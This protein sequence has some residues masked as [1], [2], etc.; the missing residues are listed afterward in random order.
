MD[1]DTDHIMRR[2][3]KRTHEQQPDVDTVDKAIAEVNEP[4]VIKRGKRIDSRSPAEP[5]D[6]KEREQL[7][8]ALTVAVPAP[9][10]PENE[11]LS[12]FRKAIVLL[13]DI[14]KQFGS[15]VA[16]LADSDSSARSSQDA[17]PR[18]PRSPTIEDAPDFQRSSIE[19]HKTMAEQV[20]SALENQPE[21]RLERVTLPSRPQP[22]P[23]PVVCPTPPTTGRSVE[24]ITLR[25]TPEKVL[26][27]RA[28]KK[29]E[30]QEAE[31]AKK[32]AER[33]ALQNVR[34]QRPDDIY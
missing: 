22:V 16:E 25:E 1:Y 11:Q 17:S 15:S 4:R 31:E 20:K 26:E 7:Q 6:G 9:Q 19:G 12:Q 18:E 27:L 14:S 28:R 33:R 30:K 21:V 5:A 10:V 24:P 23:A 8:P 3:R 13:K 32:R 34:L 29:Q 2:L